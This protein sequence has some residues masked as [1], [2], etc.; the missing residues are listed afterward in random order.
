PSA[1]L[2]NI[3]YDI[4]FFNGTNVLLY[5]EGRGFSFPATVR[6]TTEPD[7]RVATGMHPA[8]GGGYTERNYH[9]LVDMPFFVGAFD[10]E[11]AMV[12]GLNAR[13]ATYPAGTLS[14]AAREAFWADYLRMFAPQ[15]AVFGETPYDNYT[16]MM[17]FDSAAQ[18]GSAR[19]H[20]SS[21]LGLYT[22]E[23]IGQRW[24]SSVTAHEMF[25]AFNVKRLRPVEMAPYRYDV[26][27]PTPWLWVR[28]DHRL[29]RRPHAAARR[30]RRLSGIPEHHGGGRS[31]VSPRVFPSRSRTPRSPPGSIRPMARDTCT[32]P[33]AHSPAS[34]WTS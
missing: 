22:P 4:T 28:R 11:S 7:W 13:L 18:G 33:R 25:H 32:I 30:H 6:I 27:Q 8:A 31:P 17:V 2:S 10:Y 14:G 5:P 16:T 3:Q 29:L 15:A 20:Q 26:P 1:P 19:E 23:G 34:C 9:D 21:H 24:V 12:G